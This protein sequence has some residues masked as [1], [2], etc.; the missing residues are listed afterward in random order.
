MNFRD[1]NFFKQLRFSFLYKVIA[2]FISF[3][4]TRY[5]LEY[6]GLELYGIWAVLLT[7]INWIVFFDFGI[8]N[9]VKNKVSESLSVKKSV[10]AR[11]YISTGYII[12]SIFAIIVYI[13][14]FIISFFIDWTTIF[15]TKIVTNNNLQII[16]LVTLF[17]ILLNFVN[18]IIIAVFNA[19]QNASLIVLQQLL[20]QG[21]TLV[22]LFFLLIYTDRSLLNMALIYGISL[23]LSTLILSIYF[24]RK[25]NHLLP[26]LRFYKSSK[27]KS[28]FSLGMKFFYLQ[29]TILI[30]LST[31]TMILTQLLGAS[32]VTS[33]DILFKYFGLLLIIHTIINTP[34]WSMYTEAYQKNDHE[35]IEK[36]L[37]KMVWI[38]FIYLFIAIALYFSAE[39]V[40]T[41]WIG[42]IEL[43]LDKSNYIYMLLM[44]LM[45]IWYS[46][47]AYFTNGINK[48]TNQLISATIGAL[49][50]IPLSIY[51]VKYMDMG[52]NGV[53]LATIISL[54]IFGITGPIQAVIEIKKMKDLSNEK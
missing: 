14:F 46:I 25:N 43:Y 20:F 10:E 53:L 34:L 16:I 27:V 33:Y 21:F 54:S 47:F 7:F 41:L 24:Y 12:L 45:L 2:L 44:V 30:I 49:I 13:V 1:I 4:L 18:S 28:I 52:L 9:G 38:M 50:N 11:E 5:M 42:K 40:I 31:D 19:T 15:N 35:W 37:K 3:M 22:L 48:T 32:I 29:L 6:L 26:Y 36:T 23:L 8:A 51:F 17:F 39:L